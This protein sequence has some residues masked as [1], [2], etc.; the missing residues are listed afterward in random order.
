MNEIVQIKNIQ[1]FP[2]NFMFQLTKEEFDSLR[3]QNGT[4]KENPLKSGLKQNNKIE[5]I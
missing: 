5:G 4:S 2:D 1:K 3:F